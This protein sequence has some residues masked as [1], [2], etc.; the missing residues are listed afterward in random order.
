MAPRDKDAEIWKVAAELDALL[1]DLAA[2]VDALNAILM[3]PVPP[4]PGDDDERLVSP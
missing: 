2:S 3:P 4:V 1:D